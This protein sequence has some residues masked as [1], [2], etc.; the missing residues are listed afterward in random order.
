ML[1]GQIDPN[2]E[3][4]QPELQLEERS[5]KSDKKNLGL[6]SLEMVDDP[7]RT[8]DVRGVAQKSAA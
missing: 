8:N 2:V 4:S 1:L 3:E 7:S 5:L 6:V